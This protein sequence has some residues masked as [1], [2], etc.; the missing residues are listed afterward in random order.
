MNSEGSESLPAAKLLTLIHTEGESRD[1]DLSVCLSVCVREHNSIHVL[2]H[3]WSQ[4]R[5]HV[6]LSCGAE[7]SSLEKTGAYPTPGKTLK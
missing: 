2:A 4:S 5:V 3:V 7:G 6:C 1:G